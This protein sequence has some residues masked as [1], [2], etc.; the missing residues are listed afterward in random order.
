MAVHPLMVM[1]NY[2]GDL[3]V[4]LYI[5][6]DPLPNDGMLFHS[7]TLV[8]CQGAR[9]LEQASRKTHFAD[10]MNE[11]AQMYELLLLNRQPHPL[12]D[13]ASVDGDRRRVAGRILISRIESRH[14]GCGKRE[15]RATQALVHKAE[16]VR[17]LALLP[18]QAVETVCR[19]RRR[20]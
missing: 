10:V 18:V 15:I 19:E 5:R 11:P 8:Q 14:E 12:R 13:V 7:S 3:L 17:G 4:V 2:P 1:A 20:E 16:L 6:K 9:L